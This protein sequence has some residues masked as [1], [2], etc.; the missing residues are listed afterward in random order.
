[1][2]QLSLQ[3]LPLGSKN[4]HKAAKKVPERPDDWKFGN[5]RVPKTNPE[6]YLLLRARNNESVRR[7][8]KKKP[9]NQEVDQLTRQLVLDL[10]QNQYQN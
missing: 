8:R 2:I 1:M 4:K 5:T 3:L 6:K 10:V 7:C 9:N